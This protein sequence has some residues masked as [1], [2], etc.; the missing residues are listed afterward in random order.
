MG[1]SR[2]GV[3]MSEKSRVLLLLDAANE[4]ASDEYQERIWRGGRGP[5]V[6]S[7]EEAMC[8]FFDDARADALIDVEWQRLGLTGQ[9]Q[10]ALSALRDALNAFGAKVPESSPPEHILDHPDW[11]QVRDAAQRVWRAFQ[12]S[13]WTNSYST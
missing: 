8:K 9:Q 12:G 3:H 7:Y 6:S 1:A 4:F 2:I 10:E 5:E 13:E 11:P